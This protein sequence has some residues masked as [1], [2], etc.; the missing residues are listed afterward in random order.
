LRVWTTVAIFAASVFKVDWAVLLFPALL[1]GRRG[2]KA[3]FVW[4]G[5]ALALVGLSVVILFLAGAPIG[6]ASST[7]GFWGAQNPVRAA[8]ETIW[9]LV[10]YN[11]RAYRDGVLG[12]GDLLAQA[13]GLL[14][15]LA[16]AIP[17]FRREGLRPSL[18]R[19]L[20]WFN[21]FNVATIFLLINTMYIPQ[22][23]GKYI[24][25]HCLLSVLSQIR[26]LHRKVMAVILGLSAASFL[27]FLIHVD[28]G[29]MLF[30]NGMPA[31]RAAQFAQSARETFKYTPGADRWYNTVIDLNGEYPSEI[32]SL[33][34]GLGYTVVYDHKKLTLPLKS[35]YV[36]DNG[37][38]ESADIV[39]SSRLKPLLSARFGTVYENL[40][41]SPEGRRP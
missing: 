2:L 19:D 12:V 38:R 27:F 35:R 41:S 7:L 15:V 28:L 33:P 29:T 32:L 34:S 21:I 13:Q 10:S 31:A 36:I 1:L 24:T 11:L 18:A 37:S 39:A 25:C 8:F 26:Y 20:G 23:G 22:A 30:F 3:W 5:A 6:T 16:F 4:G 14:I 9:S 17:A 40:D